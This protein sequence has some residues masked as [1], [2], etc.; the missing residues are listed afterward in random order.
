[1]AKPFSK[2][3]E[4]RL[5]SCHLDLQR[6][7]RRV[8]IERMPLIV[9]CGHR[10]EKDQNA[11]F[12]AKTSKLKWP[13]SRHNVFP[14]EAVDLA[15]FPLDWKDLGRFAQLA[16]HMLEIAHLEGVTLIWG[17]SWPKFQDF[18]HFEMEKDLGGAA[19]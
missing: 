18:G 3:E 19:A 8:H 13:H 12:A 15:P 11:H 4:A 9:V 17:G 14:S 1:M 6:I 7:V 10:G 16:D 2:R 5:L